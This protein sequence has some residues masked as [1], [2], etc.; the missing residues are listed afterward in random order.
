M[1]CYIN[2]IKNKFVARYNACKNIFIKYF[3][4]FIKIPK[5]I[6]NISIKIHMKKT[7]IFFFLF[8]YFP[9]SY[10]LLW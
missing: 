3:F 6:I 5:I 4:K 8:I 1:Y 7:I 9:L 10:F 2:K